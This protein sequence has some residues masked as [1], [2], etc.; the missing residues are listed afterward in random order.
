M[1]KLVVLILVALGLL[2]FTPAVASASTPTLASL[3]KSVA[4]LQTQVNTQKAQIK[5]LQTQMAAKHTI[6]TGSGAPLATRWAI[7]DLYLDTA[8]YQLYGP[9]TSS[10]W[11]SPTS[12]IGPKGATGATGPKGATGAT[13]AKGATGATGA[14]GA[15]GATGAKGDTGATGAQ[16][17]AGISGATWYAASGAPYGIPGSDGD[18]YLN[19]ATGAVYQ[20]ASGSWAQIVNLTGPQGP[21]GDTGAT[22]A[23]GPQG[24][25]GATGEPGLKGDT[26]AQGATGP[27]GTPGLKGDTGAQ[28]ATGPTGTQG[29]KGDSGATGATGAQGP[30]G[31]TGPVGP[32]GTD[33][34]TVPELAG[35]FA[36]APY[37]SV[38]G[39][40]NGVNGPNIVFQGAN[41]NVRSTTN[42][43]DGTGTGNLIV[44]W[45]EM[46][47][48]QRTGNNNLVCG[49]RNNFTSNGCFVAGY[50]NTVSNNFA[51]VSGGTINTA[52]GQY[53]SVSGGQQNT[54]N[55]D[56]GWSAGGSF[57]NP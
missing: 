27:T 28:G 12:L 48:G 31:D 14:Q 55:A 41:V 26:G 20:M 22:G 15:T 6:H 47:A 45:D 10:G 25:T 54:V 9:K 17:V 18:F 19:N 44:G 21:Q 3:A 33:L 2:L 53:A 36:L 23:L 34:R 13:G 40:M 46:G 43:W 4:A 37:V 5:T 11:G 30:K 39:A 8:T 7:G 24:D 32:Q 49:D 38:Q 42:E 56:C 16:G 50:F 1:R 35:L 52:S 57:H 51:S 29:P